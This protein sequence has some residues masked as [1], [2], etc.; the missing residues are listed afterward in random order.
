[1]TIIL[2]RNGGRTPV[3]YQNV[4]S[5][6]VERDRLLHLG[7]WVESLD[8]IERIEVIHNRNHYA[9]VPPARVTSTSWV[10]ENYRRRNSQ[11][12]SRLFTLS[13]TGRQT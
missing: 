4:P 7:R 2:Y 9:V 11:L 5:P 8:D 12:W 13:L 10:A 6:L 1:M 3:L